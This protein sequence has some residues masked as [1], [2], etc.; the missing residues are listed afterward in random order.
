M[1]VEISGTLELEFENE[2]GEML[3]PEKEKEIEERL[4]TGEYILA[5]SSGKILRVPNLE[6]VAHVIFDVMSG[7]DYNY[8]NEEDL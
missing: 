7:T 3:S 8:L 4:R 5:L 2:N 1:Y 6:T